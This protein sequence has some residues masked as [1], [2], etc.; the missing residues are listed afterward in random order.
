MMTLVILVYIDLKRDRLKI[1]IN[2]LDI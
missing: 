2:Y 1:K